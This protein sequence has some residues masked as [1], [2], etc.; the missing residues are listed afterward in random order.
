ML[1]IH[2]DSH[3]LIYKVGCG[4]MSLHKD[5][6]WGYK[7]IV[8]ILLDFGLVEKIITDQGREFVNEVQWCI[9]NSFYSHIEYLQFNNPV[10]FKVIC[11]HY[12][13]C[14]STVVFLKLW[15]WNTAL[16]QHTIPRPTD[17]MSGRTAILRSHLLSTVGRDKMT[18][19]PI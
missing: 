17:R 7:K 18:G 4:K 8:S 12:Y 11:I 6:C 9:W 2:S 16:L 5:S 1:Q 15:V 19:M 13:F 10:S 3:R 14:R